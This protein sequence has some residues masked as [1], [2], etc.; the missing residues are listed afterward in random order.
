MQADRISNLSLFQPATFVQRPASPNKKLLFAGLGI[1]GLVGSASLVLFKELNSKRLRTVSDVERGLGLPV[2][3]NIGRVRMLVRT[4]RLLK[5]IR[6]RPKLQTEFRAILSDVMLSPRRSAQVDLPGKTLG[7]LGVESGV[8]TSTIAAALAL[9]A[10][11]KC[12][13]ETT[14]IDANSENPTLSKFFKLNGAPGLAELANGDATHTE[15]VQKRAD[16]ALS[17]ISSSAAYKERQRLDV[18]PKSISAAITNFQ[19]SSDW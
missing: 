15:C 19:E 16:G 17:L 18:A 11:E 3:A 7:V 10:T 2:I 1:L 9:V 6:T 13:F 12:G 4:H 5:L 14:L 8:G